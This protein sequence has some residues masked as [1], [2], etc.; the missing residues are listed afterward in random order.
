MSSAEILATFPARANRSEII[1]CTAGFA[2]IE[3]EVDFV[4]LEGLAYQTNGEY[5]FTNSGVELGSFF[6][7]CRE[8][9]AGM[10]LA[11]QITGVLPAGDYQEIGQVD[12]GN[13]TCQVSLVLNYLSGSPRIELRDPDGNLVETDQEGISYQ[14]RNQV[15]LLT[16]D[17]PDPGEWIIYLDQEDNQDEDAVYSLLITKQVCD[18]GFEVEKPE[19]EEDLP[20]LLT[21][22]AIPILTAGSILIVVLLVG[23]TSYLILIRQRR[24]VR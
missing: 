18:Q 21:D 6:A 13:Q 4:L 1:L 17:Y 23:G 5:L 24:S 10:E 20:F 12:V 22:Q 19:T 15:Q 16:L 7:A 14:T 3:I 2:D 8:A 11:G 9:A